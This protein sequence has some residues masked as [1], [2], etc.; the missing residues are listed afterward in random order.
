[1][2]MN[3]TRMKMK[4]ILLLL[5][6]FSLIIIAACQPAIPTEPT[7]EEAIEGVAEGEAA[8]PAAGQ[9]EQDLDTSDL[10]EIEE[11]LDLLV[12]E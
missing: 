12:L 3:Q 1:M 2:M 5:S 6:V 4:Q 8:A 7:G 10:D 9:I 11:D